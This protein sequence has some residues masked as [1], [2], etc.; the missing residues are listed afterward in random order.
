MKSAIYS[1]S[2]NIKRTKEEAVVEK[3]IDS[4]VYLKGFKH[5]RVFEEI[6]FEDGSRGYIFSIDRDHAICL[7]TSQ[8]QIKKGMKASRSERLVGINL[9]DGLKG[10]IIN[11]F[12]DSIDKNNPVSNCKDF[13]ILD[14]EVPAIKDRAI[15]DENLHTGVT[16]VDMMVPLGKGQR[17]LIIGDKVLV[18]TG[19]QTQ[20]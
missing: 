18:K 4:L 6:I 15:I 2:D 20:S 13:R 16:V 11:P 19:L 5:V 3:I 14:T 17:E 1:Y 7:L 9:G 12:G 8:I 10:K